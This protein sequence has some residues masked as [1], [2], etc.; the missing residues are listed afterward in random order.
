MHVVVSGRR[1][2]VG[3]QAVAELTKTGIIA[4][5]ISLGQY[6]GKAS[7]VA[8]AILHIDGGFQAK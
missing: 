6:S 8:G 4:R 1:E 5:A 2:D 3:K 7:F